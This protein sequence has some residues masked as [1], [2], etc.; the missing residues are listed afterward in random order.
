M[1]WKKIK[2]SRAYCYYKRS[3]YS[4][5]RKYKKEQKNFKKNL[6]LLKKD[7]KISKNINEIQEKL[8]TLRENKARNEATEGI[9]AEKDLFYSINSEL[10]ID[11][12]NRLITLSELNTN[13]L[14]SIEDQVLMIDNIKKTR[15]AR[16]C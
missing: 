9:A 8:S 14:P 6:A 7:T 2:K 16:N 12:E 5:F 4:K 15:V 3:K 11:D 10:N 1:R 13:S